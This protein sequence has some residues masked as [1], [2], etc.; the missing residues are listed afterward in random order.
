MHR[1]DEPL[2]AMPLEDELLAE[3][4]ALPEHRG[5][6]GDRRVFDVADREGPDPLAHKR[7]D[8]QG[9]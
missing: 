8:C 3:W 4:P 1:M 7:G 2:E 6:D 5:Q 9:E